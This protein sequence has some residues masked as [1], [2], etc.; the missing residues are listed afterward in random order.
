MH[1]VRFATEDGKAH[2]GVLNNDRVH[3][4]TGSEFAESGDMLALLRRGDLAA[5][6]RLADSSL[7]RFDIASVQLLAPLPNPGNVV[8][9]GLNYRSHQQEV[10]VEEPSEPTIFAK[11][12]NTIVGPGDHIQIPEAAPKRVDYEA[13]LAVVIGRSTSRIKAEDA[14]SCVAGYM[15]A[16][17]ISARDWQTK[18]PNG[19]WV[20]G[21]S[22]DT[23]LPLGPAIV[24]RDEVADPGNL[25]VTCRLSG[26]VMQDARTSEMLFGVEVLIAYL[27]RVMTLSPGDVILTGTPG[28]VGMVRTPPRYLRDG[29]IVETS[30]E[31]LGTLINPVSLQGAESTASA[32][33]LR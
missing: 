14:L 24:T 6:G 9:V 12:I 7:E 17:D 27:S 22:F 10:G 33:S 4:A 16:N 29:D 1:L 15:V 25:R 32:I 18:K 20:L 23:F 30:V 2:L 21:K 19:Q 26:E 5:F 31:G 3:F 13:E 8:G 28:G 11:F